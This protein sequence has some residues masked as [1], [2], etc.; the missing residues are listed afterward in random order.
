MFKKLF[1]KIRKKPKPKVVEP[2]EKKPVYNHCLFVSGTSTL[3]TK[4]GVFYS[5]FGPGIKDC[6]NGVLYI[7]PEEYMINK[8]GRRSTAYSTKNAILEYYGIEYEYKPN[9][10]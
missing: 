5:S 2:I 4:F 3:S 6:K 1:S 10:F 9:S 8:V 7:A